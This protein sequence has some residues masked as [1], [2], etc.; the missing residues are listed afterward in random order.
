MSSSS[1]L[2]AASAITTNAGVVC[3]ICNEPFTSI[4]DDDIHGDTSAIVCKEYTKRINGGGQTISNNFAERRVGIALCLHDSR[5]LMCLAPCAMDFLQTATTAAAGNASCPLCRAPLIAAAQLCSQN[6]LMSTQ[7]RNAERASRNGCVRVLADID[8]S[9]DAL[10]ARRVQNFAYGESSSSVGANN[11]S[12]WTAWP[13]GALDSSESSSGGNSST[14]TVRVTR[15]LGSTVGG[16]SSI[17]WEKRDD[18]RPIETILR[19]DGAWP[20]FLP[21]AEVADLCEQLLGISLRRHSA[22]PLAQ[23]SAL[24]RM[25]ELALKARRDALKER[26]RYQMRWLPAHELLQ[27]QQIQHAH[28]NVASSAAGEDDDF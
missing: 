14:H 16:A 21:D 3:A 17:A 25:H 28:S 19:M 7:L 6:A 20:K 5:H 12:V 22:A 10:I 15:T 9:F 26:V 4:H 8:N 27:D 11:H 2:I 18:R 23:S 13:R 1:F 24:S